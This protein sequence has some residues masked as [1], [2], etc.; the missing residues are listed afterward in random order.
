MLIKTIMERNPEL[1]KQMLEH[2]ASWKATD[3]TQKEYCVQHA[4]AYHVFHYWFG[5]YRKGLA[6]VKRKSGSFV[7]LKVTSSSNYRSYAE[8]V[9]PDGRRLLFH[10][11]VTS[12]YLKALIG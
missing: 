9:L 5:V 7:K 4:I 12:D 1:K 2:I 11:P 6:I 8:M 10:Q 3:L